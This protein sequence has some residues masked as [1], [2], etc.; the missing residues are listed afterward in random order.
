MNKSNAELYKKFDHLR[1]SPE[2]LAVARI[3]AANCMAAQADELAGE[4]FVIR[5]LGRM[6]ID[7]ILQGRMDQKPVVLGV[8]AGLVTLLSHSPIMTEA[9]E[10][11]QNVEYEESLAVKM[12]DR[13]EASS[14]TETEGFEEAAKEVGIDISDIPGLGKVVAIES[15]AELKSFF[16]L[17]SKFAGRDRQEPED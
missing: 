4:D 16:E 17:L 2:I 9:V 5:A 12:R 15:A 11:L 10:K 13:Q 1:T 14:E 6:G 7:E 8:I 3:L